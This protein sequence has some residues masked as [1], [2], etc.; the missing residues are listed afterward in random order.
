MTY[1]F[2]CND[3]I[4]FVLRRIEW[5]QGA[6]NFAVAWVGYFGFEASTV[7]SCSDVIK[8]QVLLVGLVLLLQGFIENIWV[9]PD[10]EM[11]IIIK[12]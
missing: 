3:L 9:I 10:L 12:Y 7:T 1:P 4:G 6:V 11:I 5:W 2:I 8:V